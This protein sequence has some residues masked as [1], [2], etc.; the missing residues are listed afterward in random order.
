ML[1]PSS[2]PLAILP[3]LTFS[4]YSPPSFF[5]ISLWPDSSAKYILSACVVNSLPIKSQLIK[6]NKVLMRK[7]IKTPVVQRHLFPHYFHMKSNSHQVKF[8]S[9]CLFCSKSWAR[10][11]KSL[12]TISKGFHHLSVINT[13]DISIL[14]SSYKTYFESLTSSLRE[15]ET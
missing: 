6:V 4:L 7:Y 12:W 8:D 2:L 13:D 11:L 5:L 15:R 9:I 10:S 3:F 14:S 1:P